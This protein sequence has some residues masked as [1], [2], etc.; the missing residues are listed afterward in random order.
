MYLATTL[1]ICGRQE[2]TGTLEPELQLVVNHLMWLL[3]TEF[4][5]SAR[6][7]SAFNC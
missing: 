5:S 2:S 3:G 7:V 1:R 6:A 4:R